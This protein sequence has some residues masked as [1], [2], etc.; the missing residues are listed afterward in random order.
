[1]L[2]LL[3]TDGHRLGLKPQFSILDSDDV[4][5][6][7]RDAGGATDNKLARH[8]QW[9][10]SLWK[11]QGLNSAGAAAAAQDDD[12]RVAARVRWPCTKSALPPTRRWISTT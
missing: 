1:M 10:I 7:L 11:N 2:R 5:G 12:E 6:V 8:W 3:R 4:M 9:T